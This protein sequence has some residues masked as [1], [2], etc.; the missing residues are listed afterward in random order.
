[1]GPNNTHATPATHLWLYWSSI[2]DMADFETACECATKFSNFFGSIVFQGQHCSLI[3][4][5]IACVL[6]NTHYLDIVKVF[7]GLTLRMLHSVTF[8]RYIQNIKS[9]SWSAKYVSEIHQRLFSQKDLRI[10]RAFWM[11]ASDSRFYFD[12]SY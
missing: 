5:C 6:H 2:Y 4:C 9:N 1:M 12:A 10:Y 3:T 7:F 8:I 11:P